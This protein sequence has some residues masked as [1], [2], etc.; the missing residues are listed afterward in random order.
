MENEEAETKYEHTLKLC[1]L[2]ESTPPSDI[3]DTLESLT[4]YFVKKIGDTYHFHHDFV[5]EVTTHVF[6]TDYPADII[7]YADIGFLRRRVTLENC[8]EQNDT[9]MIHLGDRYAEELAKRLFIEMIGRHY[10]DVVLNPCLKNENVIK[11]LRQMIENCPVYLAIAPLIWN[12][13][14]DT[15][16]FD[17]SS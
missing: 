10:L 5:M 6:G 13:E 16:D 2:P 9:F 4:G 1:G 12:N 14:I 11:T 17:R 3:R 7:K 8:N 15:E